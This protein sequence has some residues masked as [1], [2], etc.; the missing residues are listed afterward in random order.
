MNNFCPLLNKT[1][2]ALTNNN[3][4]ANDNKETEIEKPSFIEATEDQQ[5][6]QSQE[7]APYV[8]IKKTGTGW[9]N[10]RQGPGTGYEIISK[11][12]PGEKYQI[13]A[14]KNDWTK[15]QLPDNLEGWI[16]GKYADKYID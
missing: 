2:E 5:R 7:F 9:L 1:I 15:I 6:E 13:L 8:I 12:N 3:I 16:S 10:V 14:E 4:S 11:I